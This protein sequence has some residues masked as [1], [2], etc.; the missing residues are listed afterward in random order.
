MNKRKLVITGENPFG[1][2]EEELNDILDEFL[3]MFAE[4]AVK[5]RDIKEW[6]EKT[7]NYFDS[8]DGEKR[9]AA[10]TFLMK[11]ID[12]LLSFVIPLGSFGIN[13]E[14]YCKSMGMFIAA[15][16]FSC[17]RQIIAE[18]AEKN[19]PESGYF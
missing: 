1:L 6:A 7:L 5:S 16:F 19:K 11:L 10:F 9:I 15:V 12:D 8:L 4:T 17:Y 2:S 13:L 3:D 18:E 14:L